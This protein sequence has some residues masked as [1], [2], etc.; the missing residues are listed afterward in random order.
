MYLFHLVYT[1]F[2]S[3]VFGL[4]FRSNRE[5]EI[6]RNADICIPIFADFPVK[7]MSQI[8][9]LEVQCSSQLRMIIKSKIVYKPN[10]WTSHVIIDSAYFKIFFPLQLYLFMVS[11]L[12]WICERVSAR[13]R[14]GGKFTQQNQKS[15]LSCSKTHDNILVNNLCRFVSFIVL[16]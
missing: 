5:R 2:Y 11:V 9:L 15:K 10:T 7:I 14:A 13:G 4:A 12:L 6:D 3:Y 8:P 16:W 1:L